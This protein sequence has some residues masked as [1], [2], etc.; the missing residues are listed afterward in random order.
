[1]GEE[2]SLAT[3]LDGQKFKIYGRRMATSGS[4][5]VIQMQYAHNQCVSP[6]KR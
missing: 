2:M 3:Q 4:A 5:S 1:M 6:P